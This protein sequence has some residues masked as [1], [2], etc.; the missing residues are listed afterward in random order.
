M[1]A[2]Q[3]ADNLQHQHTSHKVVIHASIIW[4]IRNNVIVIEFCH[5]I[6]VRK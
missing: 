2:M 3:A 4:C 5:K 1:T 6:N